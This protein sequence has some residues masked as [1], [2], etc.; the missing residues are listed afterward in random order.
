[1][2]EI[3]QRRLLPWCGIMLAFSFAVSSSAYA[4]ASPLLE[5][6]GLPVAGVILIA[7]LQK[8][9]VAPG[10]QVML[11]LTMRNEGIQPQ[12]YR[13][14]HPL[15]DYSL[16]VQDDKGQPLPQIPFPPPELFATIGKA[17]LAPNRE[18]STSYRVTQAFELNTVGTYRITASRKI[19]TPD[20]THTTD[21]VSN[22]VILHVSD[23][24]SSDF[25]LTVPIIQLSVVQGEPVDMQCVLKSISTTP[26]PLTLEGPACGYTLQVQDFRG[27][28]LPPK[29]G[30]AMAGPPIT[31]ISLPPGEGLACTVRLSE[32]Y[33]LSKTGRYF[34]TAM[35]EVPAAGG[36]TADVYPPTV[37]ITVT[38]PAKN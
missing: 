16:I 8:T 30:V 4:Q 29:P 26:A 28:L 23:R 19:F 5:K 33:D 11:S 25:M 14:L 17:L 36:K 15:L 32:I 20:E 31:R 35:R 2:L 18:T 21:V 9:A 22:T 27:D 3:Y 37:I 24:L 38:A 1:M 10:D 6:R 7:V 34:V 13:A 12:H